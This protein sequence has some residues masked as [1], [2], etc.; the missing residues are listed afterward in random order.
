MS[1]LVLKPEVLEA[2]KRDPMLYGKV[3]AAINASPLSMPDMIRK[4]HRRFTEAKALKVMAEHLGKDEK[5]LITEAAEAE[6]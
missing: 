1:E 3:A 6:A 2:M 4:N 5:D